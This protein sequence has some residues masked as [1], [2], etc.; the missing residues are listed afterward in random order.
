MLKMSTNIIRHITLSLLFLLPA[1]QNVFADENTAN[2]IAVSDM[3]FDPFQNCGESTPCKLIE[4]LN[5]VP[6]SRWDE[7]LSQDISRQ[8]PSGHD[9]NYQFLKFALSGIKKQAEASHA[10]FA[11]ITGDFLGHHY[12]DFYFKYASDKTQQGYQAFVQKTFTFLTA[13]IGRALPDINVYSVM[14]NNDSYSGDYNL[15]DLPKFAED[16]SDIWSTLILNK[17]D[18]STFKSQF[19][20][21][22]YYAVQIPGENDLILIGLN[23]T[24]FSKSAEG[25]KYQDIANEQLQFLHDT[26][27]SAQKQHQKVIIISHIPDM[28][29]V[30]GSLKNKPYKVEKYWRPESSVRFQQEIYNYSNVIAGM[31]AG[32]LHLDWFHVV[33]NI[34]VGSTISISTLF[35][36]SGF[37]IFNYS[38]MTYQLLN[39]QTYYQSP[40]TNNEWRL[41]YDFNQ[42]Y[43][44]DCRSC[45]LIDGMNSLERTSELV[46]SYI[47]YYQISAESPITADNWPY[48]WCGIHHNS[49]DDYKSCLTILD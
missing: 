30:Y 15:T 29:D 36:N 47:N 40:N 24:V 41:E 17:N 14:G 32:H 48:Y 43:Q 37:K 21:A 1:A 22:G 25:G 8:P 49:I 6:A 35:N 9:S 2:F 33:N 45:K 10:R 42:T 5:S 20:H 28:I 16:L 27:A 19:K 31:I 38:T 46:N 12:K 4:T 34:P 26:L 44:P 11:I 39:Y 7:V 18:R 3:H 23:T 13:E